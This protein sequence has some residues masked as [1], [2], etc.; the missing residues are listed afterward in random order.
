MKSQG[1]VAGMGA[2]SIETLLACEQA[3]IKPDYYVKTLHHDRY[4]SAHPRENRVEFQIMTENSDDHNRYH[5]NMFDL[6]PEKTV[7]FMQPEHCSLD[8]FQDPGGR[9]HPPQGWLQLRVCQRG[10][11]YLC[12]DVR[13]PGCGRCEHRSR[14]PLTYGRSPACLDGLSSL[15]E[16]AGLRWVPTRVRL[17]WTPG[18]SGHVVVLACRH[19]ALEKDT[20]RRIFMYI[21]IRPGLIVLLCFSLV[22]LSYANLLAHRP[23]FQDA[24]RADNDLPSCQLFQ[25]RRIPPQDWRLEGLVAAGDFGRIL[26]RHPDARIKRLADIL[27]RARD[28][29][30]EWFEDW[31]SPQLTKVEL[32]ESAIHVVQV[33][34]E[35]VMT[36]GARYLLPLLVKNNATDLTLLTVESPWKIYK[37]PVPAGSVRG[38]C[39]NMR[40]GEIGRIGTTKG[41]LSFQAKGLTAQCDLAMDVRSKGK[42]KVRLTGSDGEP[43]AARIY[44]SGSDQLAYMPLGATQRIMPRTGEFFFYAREGFEVAL[45]EGEASVEAVRRTRIRADPKNGAR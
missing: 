1:Y 38:F 27:S 18:Q 16:C 15:I 26:L 12:R 37:L 25:I 22:S 20:S 29:R 2:H 33:P 6:F 30:E 32:A 28:Y 4:W 11:F 9:R 31:N 42:L 8:R 35:L 17:D 23:V 41:T 14:R 24:P 43:A 21:G 3:G 39:L 44:L 7:E 13:F 40:G 10:G 45:P 19:T 5:D 36:S 34:K